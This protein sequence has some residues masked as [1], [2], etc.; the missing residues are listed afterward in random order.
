MYCMAAGQRCNGNSQLVAET[1]AQT[2]G[3][4]PNF[5][6]EKFF[7]TQ[8]PKLIM[9]FAARRAFVRATIGR[10]DEGC[11]RRLRPCDIDWRKGGDWQSFKLAR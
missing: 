5:D 3:P 8:R 7:R 10:T 11:R 6:L 2:A 9:L 4:A 1:R